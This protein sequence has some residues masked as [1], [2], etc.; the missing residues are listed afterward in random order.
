MCI[1]CILLGAITHVYTAKKYPRVNYVT[2]MRGKYVNG[3]HSNFYVE[4]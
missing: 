1:R 4:L 3:M 2:S